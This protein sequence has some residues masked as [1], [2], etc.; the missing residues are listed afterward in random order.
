M[1]KNSIGVI[2]RRHFLTLFSEK[3]DSRF[4]RKDVNNLTVVSFGIADVLVSS[5]LLQFMGN[6]LVVFMLRESRRKVS[7]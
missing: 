2:P 7:G 6:V 5:R 3:L 1:L 4:F